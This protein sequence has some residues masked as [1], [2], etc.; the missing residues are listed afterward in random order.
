[1]FPCIVDVPEDVD[2]E[3][4]LSLIDGKLS[5]ARDPKQEAAAA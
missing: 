5:S 2:K 4:V 1:M 3:L